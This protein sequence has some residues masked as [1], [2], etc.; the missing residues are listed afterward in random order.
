MFYNL[1]SYKALASSSATLLKSYFPVINFLVQ[2]A[3]AFC[4][5]HCV[6][7]SPIILN[8]P[9]QVHMALY[10]ASETLP[11]IAVALPCKELRN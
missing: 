6:A 7:T 9:S 10:P 5:P 1:D 4:Y 8:T 3:T 11:D 2:L